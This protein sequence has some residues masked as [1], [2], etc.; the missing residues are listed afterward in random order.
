MVEERGVVP[1]DDGEAERRRA[2]RQAV[3]TRRRTM[4]LTYKEL[5]DLSETS[6]ATVNR[7]INKEDYWPPALQLR[8]I[9]QVLGLDPEQEIPVVIDGVLRIHV[10]DAL[11]DLTRAEQQQAVQ[12]ARSALLAAASE[13]R[14]RRGTF[15]LAPA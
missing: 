8:A 12:T 9:L 1:G 5:A 13:V 7:L 10:A 15:R 11:D 6:P 14:A 3:D 2:L 4:G